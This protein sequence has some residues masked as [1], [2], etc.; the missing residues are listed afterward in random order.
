[1]PVRW[2]LTVTSL[3]HCHCQCVMAGAGSAQNL[4]MGICV[5]RLLVDRF[6]LQS[7]MY[8]SNAFSTSTL[9][10]QQNVF[11][12]H[13]QVANVGDNSSKLVLAL[14]AAPA[15]VLTVSNDQGQPPILPRSQSS[16]HTHPIIYHLISLCPILAGSL[17][18]RRRGD[19]L[20]SPLCVLSLVYTP[21]RA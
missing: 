1:M 13:W 15:G 16:S 19:R 14:A 6:K 21:G 7:F 9:S 10:L 3:Y 18:I 2:M 20:R 4:E 11:V 5:G 17:H 8:F 12:C